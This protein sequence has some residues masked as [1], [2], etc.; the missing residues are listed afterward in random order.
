MRG[1]APDRRR[2]TRD[3]D[4][5]HLI[6]YGPPTHHDISPSRITMPIFSNATGMTF[7]GD[8]TFFDVG[9]DAHF[10]SNSAAT[11]G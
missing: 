11:S 8:P 4:F 3:L 10:H 2:N 5:V 9:G 1:L 7:P 6:I